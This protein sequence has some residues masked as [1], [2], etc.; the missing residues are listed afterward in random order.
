MSL[1]DQ[2][3]HEERVYRPK[4]AQEQDDDYDVYLFWPSMSSQ[5]VS[6]GDPPSSPLYG[7]VSL[8]S[9]S[10][11]FDYSGLSSGPPSP[12]T[13]APTL[14]CRFPMELDFGAAPPAMPETEVKVST[15]S[16]PV[17]YSPIFKLGLLFLQ[18]T[19]LLDRAIGG[20]IIKIC[21]PKSRAP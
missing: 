11:D 15:T 4:P 2:K 20:V 10:T 6:S 5:D 14:D 18:M 16:E 19:Q 7:P 9:E 3:S 12:I 8:R 13:F 21:K 17:K 1:R